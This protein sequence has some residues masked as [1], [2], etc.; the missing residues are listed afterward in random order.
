MKSVVE[1]K[2]ERVETH[3][4]FMEVIGLPLSHCHTIHKKFLQGYPMRGV[5]LTAVCKRN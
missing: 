5:Y 2:G 4:I 3:V 1:R